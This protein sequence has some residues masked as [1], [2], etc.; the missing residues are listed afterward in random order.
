[1]TLNFT[2]NEDVWVAEF[3]ATADFNLHIE[4]V[5]EGNVRIYQRGSASGAYSL[6]R[7]AMM[8]PSYN[9]VFDMDF[10]AAVYPKYMKVECATEP[11][12]AVVTFAQHE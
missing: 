12:M 10:T 8:Y 4:G 11:A 7:G 3:T 5:V 6:V 9:N 2:K 1:M